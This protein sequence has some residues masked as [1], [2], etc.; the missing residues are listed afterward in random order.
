MAA[1]NPWIGYIDRSYEQMKNEIISKFPSEVPE[2]TDHTENN[3][4]VVMVSIWSGIAEMLGYYID[5]AAREIFLSTS[6]YYSSAV[7]IAD[8]F[9]YRIRGVKAAKTTLRFS[10]AAPTTSD[11]II[12]VNTK[13]ETTDGIQFLTLNQVILLAGTTSIDVD[14]TQSTDVSQFS[15]GISDGSP[16]QIFELEENIEDKSVIVI[17]DNVQYVFS[18]NLAFNDFADRVYTTTLDTNGKTIIKFGDGINGYIPDNGF[19]ILVNYR[20]SL[21]FEGNLAENTVTELIDTLVVPNNEEVLVT[22]LITTSGG[23]DVETLEELQQNIP[24]S[25]RT[26]NRAVTEQDHIDIATLNQ[27][28]AKADLEFECGTNVKMY[29][30]PEGGGIASQALL[31][32]VR[33]D[34][35]DDTKMVF[36]DIDFLPAGV[37]DLIIEADIEVLPVFNRANVEQDV[38]NNILNFASVDNQD[39]SGTVHLGDVYEVFENTRGVDNSLVKLLSFVPSARSIVGNSSLSWTRTLKD[40]SEVTIVWRVLYISNTQYQLFADNVFIGLFDFGVLV[41]QLE[42][43]FTIQFDNYQDGDVW[44][45]ITYPYNG[46]IRLQEPSIPILNNVNLTLNMSGGL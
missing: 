41:Q 19:D 45:F 1:Q 44:E 20:T 30:V 33:D 31:D 28:V 29:I 10:I 23:K 12:P 7:K 43:D 4:F 37:I 46:T 25:I 35:Y 3:L 24:L 22:N 26:L 27:G 11:I 15:A 14:A 8:L 18:E 13:V 21:G 5:I 40:R 36:V 17:I 42:I 9:N 6:R 39:I 38:R 16:N 32:D 2:L 34:F